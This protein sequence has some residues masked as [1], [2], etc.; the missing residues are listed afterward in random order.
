[1]NKIKNFSQKNSSHIFFHLFS[2][3]ILAIPLFAQAYEDHPHHNQHCHSAKIDR[4]VAPSKNNSMTK[5]TSNNINLSSISIDGPLSVS[6]GKYG[7]LRVSGATRSIDP[8]KNG[9][10]YDWIFPEGLTPMDHGPGTLQMDM[11]MFTAPSLHQA[12]SFTFKVNVS[13]GK[14]ST[15][16]THT[17]IVNKDPATPVENPISDDHYP[18]YKIATQYQGGDRVKTDTGIYQCKPKP[19]S[20][21][22][23]QAP[24]AYAPG[25]GFS[26]SE[27]WEKIAD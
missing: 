1:M 9:L 8:G 24:A 6:V 26:W 27:A 13:N 11:V 22:C 10:T 2:V 20:G 3:A 21:W 5:H 23:G 4:T 25:T 15:V 14:T 19:F 7:T 17:L 12:T 16:A 18:A